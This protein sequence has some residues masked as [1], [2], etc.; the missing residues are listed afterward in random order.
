MLKHSVF[1]SNINIKM[2]TQKFTSF[3]KFFLMHADITAVTIQS[4]KTLSNEVKTT[5]PY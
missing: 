3:D 5:K 1:S 4:N 2:T